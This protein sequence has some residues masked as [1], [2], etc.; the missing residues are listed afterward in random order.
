MANNASAMRLSSLASSGS[1][2]QR[3]FFEYRGAR[4]SIQ[5]T[6]LVAKPAPRVCRQFRVPHP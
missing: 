1:S 2:G 5:A 6:E 4:A 3:F